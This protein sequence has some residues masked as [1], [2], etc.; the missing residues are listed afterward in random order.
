LGITG[1]YWSILDSIRQYWT[2]LGNAWQYKEILDNIQ[3]YGISK[4][5]QNSEKIE[6]WNN[7]FNNNEQYWTIFDN[8][9]QYWATLD[10]IKQYLNISYNIV[11]Y[12][13]ISEVILCNR[14]K[15]MLFKFSVPFSLFLFLFFTW[16]S[17][18]G[19]S[20]LKIQ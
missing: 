11:V 13:A 14:S 4:K 17:S 10:N 5:Y 18:R 1:Q 8:I 16:A 3:Q 12:I 19:V 7:H 15:V 6:H 20:L 9:G 2:I